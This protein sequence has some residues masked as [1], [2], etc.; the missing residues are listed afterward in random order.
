M[1]P[2]FRQGLKPIYKG[3]PLFESSDPHET[4]VGTTGPLSEH[5]LIW[6]RGKI[7]TVLYQAKLGALSFFVLRYGAAVH[8][9]PGEL[10][11]FMLFQVPICGAAQIRVGRSVVQATPK[12]GAIISPSLPLQLDWHEGCE[13]FLLK[14]PRDRIEQAC[15]LLL[16]SALS[17]PIEFNPE[18]SLSD[19]SG[20]AWQHQIGA[21]LCYL[22]QPASLLPQQ[23]IHAQE[24]A[25]IHHLLLCQPNNYTERLQQRQLPLAKRRVRVAEEYI[26]A[27]IQDPL[28]LGAIAQASGSSVRGLCLAFQEHYEMSPMAY[29]RQ[30]RLEAARHDLRHAPPGTRVTDIAFRWG[31]NHL[32]RFSVLYRDRFGEAPL[33]SLKR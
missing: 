21:L 20:Q 9:A 6:H 8:I 17:T 14:I 27:H 24:E 16:G 19:T 33:Q 1:Q 12:M 18:I 32:G 10:K 15:S 7:N 25:L 23:W 13:Q 30:L 29:V 5:E 28:T 2:W 31:F 4:R 3:L 11:H 22:N 26:Q